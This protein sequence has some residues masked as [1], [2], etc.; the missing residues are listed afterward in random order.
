MTYL[1]TILIGRTHYLNAWTPASIVYLNG[2]MLLCVDSLGSRKNKSTVSDVN[3]KVKV[4]VFLL[5]FF[6]LLKIII[7]VT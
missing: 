7:Y 2:D 6:Y 1:N 4:V 3:F 5:L